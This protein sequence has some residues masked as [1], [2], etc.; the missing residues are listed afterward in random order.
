MKED[1]VMMIH[2][3]S[4][5]FFVYSRYWNGNIFKCKALQTIGVLGLQVSCLHHH[6]LQHRDRGL[7]GGRKRRNGGD[8]EWG[9]MRNG[10]G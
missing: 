9:G 7:W 5:L 2:C 6:N 4:F 10:G 3:F 8:E 1:D